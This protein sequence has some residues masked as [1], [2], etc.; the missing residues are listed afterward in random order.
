MRASYNEMLLTVAQQ[1]IIARKAFW[2]FECDVKIN[3]PVVFTGDGVDDLD[4][5]YAFMGNYPRGRFSVDMG[6]DR[7]VYRRVDREDVAGIRAQY[8]AY[9]GEVNKPTVLV[10]RQVPAAIGL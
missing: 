3:D 10:D 6:N 4:K 8:V 1:G 5:V 7:A 2:Y 9:Y